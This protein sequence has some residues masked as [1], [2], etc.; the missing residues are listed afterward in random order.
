M[1]ILSCCIRGDGS[2]RASGSPGDPRS[3]WWDQKNRYLHSLGGVDDW[4]EAAER[5][6]RELICWKKRFLSIFEV[7]IDIVNI[8][9][10]RFGLNVV[11]LSEGEVEELCC[12]SSGAI[13]GVGDQN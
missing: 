9:N 3:V 12:L 7:H 2:R 6:A 13:N 4:Q 11:S 8:F 5:L 1:E 10:N